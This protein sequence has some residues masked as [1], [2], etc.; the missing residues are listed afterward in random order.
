[1]INLIYMLKLNHKILIFVIFR[2]ILMHVKNLN[3]LLVRLIYLTI[4]ILIKIQYI[5][6][7]FTIK[8]KVIFF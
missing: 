6:Y 8:L 4:I 5:I 1:M 3:I 7:I 2:E